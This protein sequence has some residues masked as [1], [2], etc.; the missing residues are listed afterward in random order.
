MR[1][2]V[3]VIARAHQRT[4]SRMAEAHRRGLVLEYLE[5]RRL[6]IAQHRQVAASWLQILS[7]REHLH[8]VIAQVTH[9]LQNFFVGFAEPSIRPD[10]VAMSG[11]PAL[12]SFSS[13][14][15]F[16]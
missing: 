13:F 5:L 15:E 8:I 14:S 9:D 1:L 7:Q 10:L 4:A 16:R 6:D 2:L 11:K 12:K 3:G